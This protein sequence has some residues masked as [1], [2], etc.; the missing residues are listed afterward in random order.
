MM[1]TLQTI[2]IA[3]DRPNIKTYATQ[4]I[5]NTIFKMNDEQ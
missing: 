5:L 1:Y 4:V 2:I 3:K